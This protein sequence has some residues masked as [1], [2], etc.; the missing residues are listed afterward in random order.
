[1]STSIINSDGVNWIKPV[2]NNC[3]DENDNLGLATLGGVF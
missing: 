3:K 2:D 1:M